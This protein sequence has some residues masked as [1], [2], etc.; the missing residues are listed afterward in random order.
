MKAAQPWISLVARLA[1]AAIWLWAGAAKAF[2][3][4]DSVAA[5]KAYELFPDGIA[6]II[7]WGLPWFEIALGLLLLVG[8]LTR[9]AAVM[10]A[11]VF[12]L[13]I[14]GVA[15]AWARGLTIDC[16]CFGGGGQ[17][18]ADQTAYVEEILRDIGFILL[19]AWLTW[20]PRSPVSV[21]GYLTEPELVEDSE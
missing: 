15:S 5:V 8:L 6:T 13:F 3:P 11:I 9:P 17:V 1:L 20:K 14:A 7:G 10:S 2:H 18:A 21:D 16:G 4:I 12:A 19:A